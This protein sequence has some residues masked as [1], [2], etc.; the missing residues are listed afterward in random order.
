MI[1]TA[2]ANASSQDSS[3]A[4]QAEKALNMK[5]RRWLAPPPPFGL[6]SLFDGVDL[7]VDLRRADFLGVL[8]HHRIDQLLHLR[9]VGKRNPLQLA[10]LLQ[11]DQLLLVLARF[12]LAAERAGFLAG[13]EHRRL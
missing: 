13:L 1:S 12:R 11:R 10:R 6:S 4:Y 9:A 3:R 7:G 8:G 2:T 5:K